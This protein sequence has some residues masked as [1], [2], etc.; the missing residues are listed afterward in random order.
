M[1]IYLTY[2]VLP[3]PR[4]LHLTLGM[5]HFDLHRAPLPETLQT[6]TLGARFDAPL[7]PNA[8]PGPGNVGG[9]FGPGEMGGSYG[10]TT[11]DRW[12]D[13]CSR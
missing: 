3:S 4:L 1:C 7:R 9:S 11:L 8:L 2:P 10:I 6:L 12:W 5:G 13:A